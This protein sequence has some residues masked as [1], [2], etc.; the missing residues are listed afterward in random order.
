MKKHIL[1]IGLVI[2]LLGSL[3]GCIENKTEATMSKSKFE[4]ISSRLL[5]GG[6]YAE[7]IQPERNYTFTTSQQMFL[8]A[9]L[10][11]VSYD[12]YLSGMDNTNLYITRTDST[13]N[14]SVEFKFYYKNSSEFKLYLDENNKEY[15]TVKI[16]SI[17]P[18]TN[19]VELSFY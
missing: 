10:M 11:N 8:I 2:L 18:L 4:H 6:N 13:K 12:F 16:H 9:S 3:S 17:D 14:G 19:T 7:E 15:I 5:L 1:F